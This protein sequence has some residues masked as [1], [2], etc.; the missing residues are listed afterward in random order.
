MLSTKR[1]T[2]TGPMEAMQ[3]LASTGV[4]GLTALILPMSVGA[5]QG[6]THFQV[7]LRIVARPPA[8]KVSQQVVSAASPGNPPHLMFN[9][10]VMTEEKSGATLIVITTEF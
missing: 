2:F 1:R 3:Y 5:V 9:D 8:P 7:S 6:S 10:R 4:M